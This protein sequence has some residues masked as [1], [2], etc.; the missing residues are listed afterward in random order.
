M[1]SESL[2]SLIFLLFLDIGR[3]AVPV[4]LSP[5]AESFQLMNAPEGHLGPPSAGLLNAWNRSSALV[6]ESA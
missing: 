6:E 5:Q 4:F 3:P 1:I 2:L